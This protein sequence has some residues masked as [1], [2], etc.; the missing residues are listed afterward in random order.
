MDRKQI[1]TEYVIERYLADQLDAADAAAFEAHYLSEPDLVNDLEAA[2]R[3][4]EGLAVLRERGE[5]DSLVEA[6]RR[7]KLPAPPWSL[8]AAV[9]VAAVGVWLWLGHTTANPMVSALAELT[10]R[11][12]KAVPVT[13]TVM[14]ARTRGATSSVEVALPVERGAIELRLLASARASD[15][16][17]QVTLLR[18]DAPSGTPPV[19]TAHS[20]R[21]S[22]DGLVTVY[23]DTAQVK[24]GRYAIELLPEHAE[25]HGIASDRFIIE[26]R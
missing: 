4:K 14:L 19:A 21:V 15:A 13:G 8:A 11:G 22:D 10:A 16:P 2:L 20:L 23:V 6:R 24:P 5:L 18:A 7:W 12:G 9:A 1:E 17:Y 25:P 3:L 26:L